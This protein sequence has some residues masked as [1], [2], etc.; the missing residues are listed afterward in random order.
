MNKNMVRVGVLGASGYTGGELLRIFALHK[1]V[2]VTYATSRE[3]AGKPI[4]YVHPH[5]RGYFKLNFSQINLDEIINRVDVVFLALP[6]GVSIK[7]VPKLLEVG[8]KVVDLSAD[9]RLKNPEDYKTWYGYEHPYPDLLEKAV[10]GMPELHRDELKKASLIASPGCN[11]TASLLALIPLARERLVELDRIVVDVK[12]GSSEGGAK[13][14]PGRIHSEK[15]NSIRPYNVEGHRHI[16]EVEQELG[17]IVNEQVKVGMSLHAVSS[18]RGALATAYTWP[19]TKVSEISIWKAF[20]KSYAKEPFVRIIRGGVTRYPDTKFVIGSNYA[21]VGFA[22]DK[23]VGRIIT[24]AAIDNLMKGA[25]GQAVQA[26]N[27]MMGYDE[28]EGLETPP[29]RP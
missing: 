10:Y 17:I 1:Q 3:Y 26:F 28:R 23:R 29:L 25:S 24:I 4:H 19:T 27:I 8:L 22:V 2:E 12:A 9:F 6:H 11:A 18:V 21:D 20:I 5:L 7:F 15:E 13:P 16:A 14:A